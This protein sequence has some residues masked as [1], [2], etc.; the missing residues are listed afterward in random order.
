MKTQEKW[1]TNE[2]DV[3]T[4]KELRRFGLAARVISMIVETP[5]IIEIAQEREELAGAIKDFHK[6]HIDLYGLYQASSH[7]NC[8]DDSLFCDAEELK[9]YYY[10]D[11]KKE[12]NKEVPFSITDLETLAKEYNEKGRKCGIRHITIDTEAKHANLE[13]GWQQKGARN[14]LHLLSYGPM[15]MRFDII[16]GLC[17]K[18]GFEIN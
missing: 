8:L 11:F 13:F 2:Q 12:A 1:D 15:G 10:Q 16:Y 17:M 5:D 7:A 9:G 6:D 18:Y 4:E 14:L 3:M